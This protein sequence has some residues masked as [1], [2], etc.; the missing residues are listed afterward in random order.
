MKRAALLTI[1]VLMAMVS[2]RAFAQNR[3]PVTESEH[4]L[5][6]G[7]GPG[8]CEFCHAP[9]NVAPVTGLWNHKLSTY[10]YNSFYT[11]TTYT[12]GQASLPANSPSRLCLSCHDGTVAV[13]LLYNSSTPLPTSHE[14]VSNLGTDFKASHP[15][16]FDVWNRDNT[17]RDE[18]FSS[19]PRKTANESVKLPGGRIECSTC[20]EAHT[21]DLDPK[22]KTKFLAVNNAKGD[23]CLACH[24]TMKPAPNV[25]ANW[26]A[27]A[28]AISD[29]TEGAAVTGY[30]TV[31]EGACMNC[32]AS[33]GAGSDWL[34][35]QGEASACFPCHANSSSMNAWAKVWAGNEDSSKYMHP[36]NLRVHQSSENLAVAATPRHSECWDCHDSHSVKR[37]SPSSPPATQSSLGSTSGVNLAGTATALAANE[38]EVCFKC[39]ADTPNK[40][41]ST[42]G[43]TKFGTAPERQVDATNVRTDFNTQFSRHNVVLSNTGRTTVASRETMRTLD[44]SP[45]R[46]LSGEYIYCTDCHNNENARASGGPAGNGPHVSKYPHILERRYDMNSTPAAIGDTVLSLSVPPDGGDPLVGPF[47]L[48]NK[49]HEVSVLLTSGDTVFKHHA[50]HVVGAGISCAVCHAPHGVSDN[51][52]GEDAGHHARLINLDKLMIGPTAASID[53]AARTCTVQCHFSNRPAVN[54]VAVTY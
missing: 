24:D 42:R 32:H 18:L 47:A 22:R 1:V 34:I 21:P 5:S 15:F 3:T 9:H 20:H 17:L 38:Y 19:V 43:Y 11:S 53:T 23:L 33:H 10:E 13:G 8:A 52:P 29:A 36:V 46:L 45:G 26:L 41:Q 27:S 30:S 6:T 54:H 28:H 16:A 37:N 4:N 50:S 48:C 51:V 49:C 31:G 39:H 2:P 14:L 44:G 25:L 12:Q 35:K 7:T 40:P